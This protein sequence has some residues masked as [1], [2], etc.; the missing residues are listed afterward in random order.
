VPPARSLT[1]NSFGDN[2][3]EDAASA[4]LKLN[5]TAAAEAVLRLSYPLKEI[6]LRAL[7]IEERYSYPAVEAALGV[8]EELSMRQQF[9]RSKFMFNVASF[10]THQVVQDEER[11]RKRRL[12]ISQWF[13]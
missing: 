5:S 1:A 6:Y 9:V 10:G 11:E 7:R 3:G 8:L 13:I 12:T 4:E 2:S